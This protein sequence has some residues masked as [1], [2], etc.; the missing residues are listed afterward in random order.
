MNR[1]AKPSL[2][3]K[4]KKVMEYNADKYREKV[5]TQQAIESNSL[6]IPETK[7]VDSADV[8]K[9]P[10]KVRDSHPNKVHKNSKK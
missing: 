4:Q 5:R 10:L 7:K 6:K 2:K 3:T 1:V 9:I 8:K